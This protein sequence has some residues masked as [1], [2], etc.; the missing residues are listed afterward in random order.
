MR[1]KECKYAHFEL[2]MA[3]CRR[4]PPQLAEGAEGL[5][6]LWPPVSEDDWCGEF[7]PA[8]LVARKVFNG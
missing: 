1:C 4:N 8:L 5:T 7:A 3:F 2:K 6:A